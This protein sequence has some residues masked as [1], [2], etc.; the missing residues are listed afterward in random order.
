MLQ[1]GGGDILSVLDKYVIAAL[2]ADGGTQR[3]GTRIFV[4]LTRLNCG[5]S[6]NDARSLDASNFAVQIANSPSSGEQL[7]GML[8][9]VVNPNLISKEEAL[10]IGSLIGT[11]HLDADAEALGIGCGLID[12]LSEGF[13][14]GVDVTKGG[15]AKVSLE[16]VKFRGLGGVEDATCDDR[17]VVGEAWINDGG[18]GGGEVVEVEETA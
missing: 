10:A 16:A 13:D 12:E 5:K 8:R 17:D 9:D 3:D 18:G 2:R 1:I 7:D 6:A 4:S 11:L 14:A 15:E